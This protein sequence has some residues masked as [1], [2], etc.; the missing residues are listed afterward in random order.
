[1]GIPYLYIATGATLAQILNDR[2]DRNDAAA[3]FNTTRQVAQAVRIQTSTELPPP[4]P[5]T[6]ETGI[7]LTPGDSRASKQLPV[8]KKKP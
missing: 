3:V 5:L 8:T 4:M 7:V 2:G 6:P 1:V